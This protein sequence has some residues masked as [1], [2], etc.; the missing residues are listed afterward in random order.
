MEPKA[1]I[2]RSTWWFVGAILVIAWGLYLYFYLPQM[3]TGGLA[4]PSLESEAE[5][6][7]ADFRWEV[8][9]L[10]GRAVDL[11]RYQG[12]PVFLNIWATW[13]G[14]CR[15]EMPSIARLAANPK[16]KD[17]AFLCVAVD[18][19]AAVRRYAEE[20]KLGMTVLCA[21]GPPPPVFA[22]DGIPATFLIAPDGQIVSRH[23]GAAH[24]DAPEVVTTL[25]RMAKKPSS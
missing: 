19:R 18:E 7:K 4:P 25:E 8:V 13:C 3:G 24:W 21:D 16:L 20:H 10:E 11:A 14:P 1:L 22:T 9:D 2:D 12:K 5:A 15:A 17:V 23:I 6:P